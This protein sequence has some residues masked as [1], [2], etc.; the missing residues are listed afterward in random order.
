MLLWSVLAWLFY[1]FT[2]PVLAWV[3]TALDLVVDQGRGAAKTL[4]N[5]PAGDVLAALDTSSWPG[6]WLAWLKSAGKSL[7]VIVWI[8]GMAVLAALPVGL[9]IIGRRYFRDK[10]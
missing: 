5:Q 6:Q 10:P 3:A 9:S 8:L 4:G 1:S 2:D 7:V